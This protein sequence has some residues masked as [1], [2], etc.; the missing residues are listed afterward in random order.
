MF[1]ITYIITGITVFETD[2]SLKS[3]YKFEKGGFR[4]LDFLFIFKS[5][6]K[7]GKLDLWKFNE[8][9]ERCIIIKEN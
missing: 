8:D 3:Q 1:I 7:R 9:G 6:G 2:E 4:A 5:K